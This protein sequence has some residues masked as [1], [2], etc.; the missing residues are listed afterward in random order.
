MFDLGNDGLRYA[1]VLFIKHIRIVPHDSSRTS[2]YAKKKCA[3]FY[4]LV[5]V[6]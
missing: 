2:S 4:T 6:T 1:N 3:Q 5:S